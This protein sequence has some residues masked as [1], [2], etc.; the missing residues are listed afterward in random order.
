MYASSLFF[1]AW[2]EPRLADRPN[3]H[4]GTHRTSALRPL[5]RPRPLRPC[6]SPMFVDPLSVHGRRLHG[7]RCSLLAAAA[8]QRVMECPPYALAPVGLS[9]SVVEQHERPARPLRRHPG[10]YRVYQAR[11]PLGVRSYRHTV[12]EAD[13]LIPSSGHGDSVAGIFKQP[14][15]PLPVLIRL[16]VAPEERRR[17]EDFV[18]QIADWIG[19]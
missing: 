14:Q 4:V 17:R 12:R 19:H 2:P 7:E 9:N 5:D 18:V 13:Q 1:T 3:C 10:G 11:P 6:T 15:Q 16:V 8:E